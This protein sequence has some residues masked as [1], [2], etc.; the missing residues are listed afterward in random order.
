MIYY[1]TGN[2]GKVE[3]ANRRLQSYKINLEQKKLDGIIEIQSEDIR[4]I[5]LSKAKQAFERMNVPL[6]VNDSAWYITALNGFP[7]AYMAYIN[8][9][10]TPRDLLNLMQD[11]NNREVVLEE[12]VTYIDATQQKVFNHRMTGTI[13]H[14]QQGEGI[15]SDTVISLSETGRSIADSKKLNTKSSEQKG[16][17]EEFGEW[18]KSNLD[19]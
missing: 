3:S 12:V 6:V 16:I 18:Y 4:E 1:I 19:N 2:V 10:L 9:W 7:G 11:K 8:K 5:S 17:W 15:P 13:L 14:S